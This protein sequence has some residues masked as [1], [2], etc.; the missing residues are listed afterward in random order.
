MG[1]FSGDTCT[2]HDFF[3]ACEEDRDIRLFVGVDS[4]ESLNNDKVGSDLKDLLQQLNRHHVARIHLHTDWGEHWIADAGL[5]HMGLKRLRRH[6][7]IVVRLGK[8]VANTDEDSTEFSGL[9]L[10]KTPERWQR[11]G[12]CIWR[13]AW[14]VSPPIEKMRLFQS[15]EWKKESGHFGQEATGLSIKQTKT[16]SFYFT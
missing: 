11:L 1:Y 7:I 3:R 4:R 5:P 8:C 2:A 16:G 14:N 15:I 10:T 12:I 6:N 9:I 13:L